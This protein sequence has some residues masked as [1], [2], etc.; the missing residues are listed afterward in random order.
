MPRDR[1]FLTETEI[2][3]ALDYLRDNAKAAAQARANRIYMEEY[4][5][6]MK[7]KLMTEAFMNEVRMSFNKAEQL[8]YEDIRY[9]R[10]LEAMKEAIEIDEEH[11]FRREAAIARID[12]WRT[13]ESNIRAAT[14]LA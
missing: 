7:A 14:R 6:T 8:A 10:H 2:S 5:K 13:Q 11:R 9:T 12:A 3:E 1:E 4:R